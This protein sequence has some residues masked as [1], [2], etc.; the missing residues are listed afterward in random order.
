MKTRVVIGLLGVRLDVR[1]KKRW[2]QWRPSV[3]LCQQDDLKVH[4]F[5]MLCQK[6]FRN[7]AL[8]V[9]RDIESVSPDTE[10]RLHTIEFDDPWDFDGVF[11]SLHQFA[12][13]YPFN[14]DEEEYL[15]H[16]TTGTHVVQICT[17]L[18]TEARYF[19]GKLLQTAPSTTD[20][21]DIA[22]V[23]SIIDLDLSKYDHIASRFQQET[24]ESLVFLKSGIETRNPAFNKLIEQIEMVAI[25][26]RAPMLIT[27]PTGAGKS[28]LARKIYD[29]KRLKRQ[30][31]GQ[32][33]EINCATLR[34][35]GAMSALFGHV[36]GAFT[37]ALT[38][39]P[40]L[41]RAADGGILFLDEVGELGLDEQA[42]LLRAIEEKTFMPM[43]SDR[44]VSSDFQ[45]I[46]GTNHDL[47][48]D[49]AQGKF[50]EDLLARMNL[51]TFRL[52]GLA[53]RP[54][55][56]GPNLFFELAQFSRQN[57]RKVTFNKE[58]LDHYLEFATSPAAKWRANFRDL[59]A[60][61]TRMATLTPGGRI[62]Q[63]VVREE[64]DRLKSQWREPESNSYRILVD[65]LGAEAVEEIDLFDKPQLARVLEV[66]RDSR[67]LAEAG[68]SLFAASRLKKKSAND[69]DRLRKYL[70]KFGLDPRDVMR[71]F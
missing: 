63:E 2:S 3:A 12:I 52:P 4:R 51:W 6:P 70:A 8:K 66:C 58:A 35:D 25:N 19:P 31:T 38:D 49:V 50:R 69:S 40:G 10:V 59:N 44:E 27:G 13:D 11:T 60:S 36:R 68:R 43:G 14:L 32:F 29:L 26:S 53:D 22:G 39:R 5:E 7:N 47:W 30:V 37:G 62:N 33:A 56:L 46:A 21:T 23:Y 34:G 42:M 48:K 71:N 1:G 57:G 45:L 17:F 9:I 54:E 24:A 18:L 64:I 65:F 16:I 41:L 61:V 28:H 67:S 55:D 20:H 15:F